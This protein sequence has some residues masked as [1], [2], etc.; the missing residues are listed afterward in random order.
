MKDLMEFAAKEV[1]EL[2][3]EENFEMHFLIILIF[4][5]VLLF[6]NIIQQDF[7]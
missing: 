2:T 5:L 1:L 3:A 4:C 6:R 7:Q